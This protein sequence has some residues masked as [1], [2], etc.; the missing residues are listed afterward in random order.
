MIVKNRRLSNVK[1]FSYLFGINGT[2]YRTLP[3][4]YWN[5]ERIKDIPENS[6][7]GVLKKEKRAARS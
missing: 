4:D 7:H 6:L 3:E 5:G 2:Y 1:I